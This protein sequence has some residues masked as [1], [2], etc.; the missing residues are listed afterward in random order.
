M[1]GICTKVAQPPVDRHTNWKHNLP[2][3][4]MGD[5]KHILLRPSRWLLT[6]Q[7]PLNFSD[8]T[9]TQIFKE[10]AEGKPLREPG[11][12][13][14]SFTPRVFPT[15]A[16][17]STAHEEEEVKYY[18]SPKRWFLRNKFV[19]LAGEK[20]GAKSQKRLNFTKRGRPFITAT[21]KQRHFRSVVNVP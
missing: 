14:V 4:R 19:K 16:R 9:A 8:K 2:T 15:A 17:E 6:P 10:E 18:I 21:W 7:C 20:T 11:R 3:L 5:N 13:Q 12:I 1:D